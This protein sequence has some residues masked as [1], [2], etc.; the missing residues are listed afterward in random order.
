MLRTLHAAESSAADRRTR[1]RARSQALAAAL[2]ANRVGVQ[3]AAGA[4]DRARLARR[5]RRA[6]PRPAR[7]DPQAAGGR[8]RG[9]RSTSST[10]SAS[11][12]RAATSAA[13][14]IPSG[15]TTA[16]SCAAR[17]TSSKRGRARRTAHHRPQDRPEPHHAEDGHRRRRHA[18]A[19]DLRPRHREDP[20]AARCAKAGCSTR[21]PPA[22]SPSIRFR[23]ARRTAAPG[24]KRS[25]SSTARSSSG[26]LP[27]APAERACTWCDFRSICGPDE[28]RH[29]ARKAADPLGDLDGAAGDA[30][31]G[32][33]ARVPSTDAAQA[34]DAASPTPSTRRSSSRPRPAP[35]RRRRSSGASSASS[36][37]GKAD[38]G[39]I[40]A[41]TFT[42]KAAGELKLRLRERLDSARR[43]GRPGRRRTRA[44]RSRADAARRS[45]RRHDP[46]LLRRP[47]ARAAGRSGVDPLFEVLTEPASARL[48]DEAFGR[49]LQEKL[50]EPPEGV[51]RA[52]RRRRSAATTARSTGCAR[53]RGSSR[54]GATSR[55]RGRATRSIAIARST[56][57]VAA[58]AR[59]RRR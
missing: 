31:S 3:G 34:R 44:A 37:K 25:R 12:T 32:R 8:R 49:W 51:R 43:G 26:F 20:G 13:S 38:V 59:G 45:A 14:A 10:A 42:E 1:V 54:S 55:R 56:S 50:A 29:V 23:F 2:D 47:P 41:V 58:A 17:S 9:R 33:R 11:R 46:R 19:G 52:L 30:M 57:L 16:S 18:A 21:P 40:V 22:A 15:S 6:R 5:D 48:F 4:S 7:L 28:A 36:P 27:A 39:E 53:R 35:A 24:S